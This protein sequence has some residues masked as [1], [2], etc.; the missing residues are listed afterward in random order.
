MVRQ[1]FST[2][3][4]FHDRFGEQQRQIRQQDP[5]IVAWDDV[6]EFV[7]EHL[8]ANL[9][10]GYTT[11]RFRLNEGRVDSVDEQAKVVRLADGGVFSCGGSEGAPVFGPDGQIV[12][13]LGLNLNLVAET[14]R[15]LAF[16][17][18]ATG[19]AH[20]RWP[21]EVSAP[22]APPFGV[23]IFMRQTVRPDQ[24]GAWTEHATSLHCFCVT[25]EGNFHSV[26]GE[27]KATLLRAIFRATVRTKPEQDESL[28]ASLE[29]LEGELA[30]T[31]RRPEERELRQGIR[32]AVTPLLAATIAP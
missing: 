28:M 4:A 19:A 21:P 26:E 11:Q 29:R 31:L 27:S 13:P 32:H 2:W 24:H 20:L 6:V 7:R 22:F 14:L 16:P 12:G 10:E 9:P 5:G 30:S 8:E 25:T 1:G 18:V 15:R 3:R 23:L 17:R